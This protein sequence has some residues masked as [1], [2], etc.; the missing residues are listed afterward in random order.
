MQKEI[1][2]RKVKAKLIE[3]EV[4]A[5]AKDWI[6]GIGLSLISLFGGINKANADI[7]D[8][9][10]YLS[11]I[12]PQLKSMEYKYKGEVEFKKKPG[13]FDLKIGPYNIE[14]EYSEDDK[15]LVSYGTELKKDKSADRKS[16][17]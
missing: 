7:D 15:G 8:V 14:V 1:I 9:N 11:K 5:G 3:K 10:K 4:E 12:E 2:L 17:V 6:A 13:D 16:V